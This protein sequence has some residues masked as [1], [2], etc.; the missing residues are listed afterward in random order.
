VYTV[1]EVAEIVEKHEGIIKRWL[2]SGEFPNSFRN[3]DK[4]G[5]R[6]QESDLL[7]LVKVV[8]PVGTMKNQKW[9]LMLMKQS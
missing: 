3:S 4:E 2:R 1:K 6:I 7:K 8:G 9:N 5:W